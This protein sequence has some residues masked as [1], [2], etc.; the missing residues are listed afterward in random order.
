[1]GVGYCFLPP[2]VALSDRNLVVG[3]LAV[4]DNGWLFQRVSS[5]AQLVTESPG[6]PAGCES[7]ALLDC[8]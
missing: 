2:L 8:T 3:A 6:G 7:C 5:R 1:M 4:V